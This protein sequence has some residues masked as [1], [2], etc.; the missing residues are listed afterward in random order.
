M[1]NFCVLRV[2][3]LKKEKELT[4]VF[5]LL[6]SNLPYWIVAKHMDDKYELYLRGKL[7]SGN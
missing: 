2:E 7:V 4:V 3:I 5:P 6:I 1:A